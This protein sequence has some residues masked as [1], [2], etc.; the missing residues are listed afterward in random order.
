MRCCEKP[1]QKAHLFLVKGIFRLFPPICEEN[2]LI[3]RDT[4]S[5]SIVYLLSENDICISMPP[6]RLSGMGKDTR[7][8]HIWIDRKGEGPLIATAIHAGHEVRRELLP[9]LALDDAARLRE[10]DPF[11]DSWVDIVPSWIVDTHSRFEVDLNRPRDEAVYTSPEMAWGLNLW[12]VPLSATHIIHSLGEYDD[13]YR[14][15]DKL[16]SHVAG[17]YRHFV[18]LDLH[19]YNY[20]RQGPD[21][22]PDDPLTHPE[23]NI[24]TGSLDRV[25]F[26]GVV[27]RFIQDL[28]AFDFLGRHLDVRENVKFKGRQ[29]AG[30][31]H[32]RFPQSACVLAVEFKKFFMD[33]WTGE[34]YAKEVRAIHDA[35]QSTLPGIMEELK[36]MEQDDAG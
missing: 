10:E 9:L 31:I 27:E 13:F 35:L 6:I 14:E 36:R 29:L 2:T 20:R 5:P 3:F 25:R 26:S 8:E 4:L 24:G 28:H 17:R 23:V 16:L 15:L 12:K 32:Q 34:G 11:T 7:E 21:L 18:V 33:E 30:W 1:H 19:A 22:P